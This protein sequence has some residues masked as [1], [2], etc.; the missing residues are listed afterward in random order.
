MAL[1]EVTGLR[2]RGASVHIALYVPTRGAYVSPRRAK[3]VIIRSVKDTIEHL[4]RRGDLVSVAAG[5]LSR[6]KRVDFQILRLPIAKDVESSFFALK[7]MQQRSY[8]IDCNGRGAYS[9]YEVQ[10]LRRFLVQSLCRESKRFIFKDMNLVNTFYCIQKVVPSGSPA[11][12]RLYRATRQGGVV[13][14]GQTPFKRVV[15]SGTRTR[16]GRGTVTVDVKRS[17]L[18]VDTIFHCRIS[19]SEIEALSDSMSD[20]AAPIS[21]NQAIGN[22]EVMPRV[23][24]QLTAA[25]IQSHASCLEDRATMRPNV[26]APLFAPLMRPSQP[27][28]TIVRYHGGCFKFYPLASQSVRVELDK[29][30][31]ISCGLEEIRLPESVVSNRRGDIIV[32]VRM[33]TRSGRKYL[34]RE[35]ISVHG[36]DFV[37]LESALKRHSM[38]REEESRVRGQIFTKIRWTVTKQRKQ[39]SN[40]SCSAS[41]LVKN[42]NHLKQIQDLSERLTTLNFLATR[43]VGDL[44][45]YAIRPRTTVRPFRSPLAIPW[46]KSQATKLVRNVF[47]YLSG[48]DVSKLP[49]EFRT[50]GQDF[51]HQ[52]VSEYSGKDFKLPKYCGGAVSF[53]AAN[54]VTN[55]RNFMT[56]NLHLAMSKWLRL[57]L[58][59]DGHEV[60][61]SD[62]K[63]AAASILMKTQIFRDAK[64][65]YDSTRSVDLDSEIDN[66]RIED[67]DPL[68]F[69]RQQRVRF[70][71]DQRVRNRGRRYVTPSISE[72]HRKSLI[73]IT[74]G[75]ELLVKVAISIQDLKPSGRYMSLAGL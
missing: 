54:V 49:P 46:K 16:P 36:R 58:E 1:A 47:M 33:Q 43:A 42:K 13:T 44:L 26:S 35:T 38:T 48:R 20:N 8:N 30:S 19:C 41:K 21:W 59:R 50:W 14:F 24:R 39:I 74:D 4:Q 69:L 60:S 22:D 37:R 32:L 63:V 45:F 56:R 75:F 61:L 9:K 17:L 51:L 67:N 57:R 53:H 25:E 3:K 11:E 72:R 28:T 34:R 52:V 7:R 40:V 18:S 66:R 2:R 15:I 29:D 70:L 55:V 6:L 65:D 62:A 64:L 68:D 31:G 12:V 23:R 10:R 5:A 71:R 27:A 73:S